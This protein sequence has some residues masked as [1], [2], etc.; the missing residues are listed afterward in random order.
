[1]DYAEALEIAKKRYGENVSIV[2]K[3]KSGFTTTNPIPSFLGEVT[4]PLGH[5]D[6]WWVYRSLLKPE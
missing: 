5:N 3:P 4:S 2:R 6:S 1:M